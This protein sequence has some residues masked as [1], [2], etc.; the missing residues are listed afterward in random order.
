MYDLLNSDYDRVCRMLHA[1][2]LSVIAEIVEEEII[3]GYTLRRVW[4]MTSGDELEPIEW[5]NK[6]KVQSGFAINS[7][8]VRFVFDLSGKLQNLIGSESF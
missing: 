1:A 3:E 6:K 5:P 8:N 7:D 4:D 2:E